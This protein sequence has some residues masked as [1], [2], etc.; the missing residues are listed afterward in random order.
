LRYGLREIRWALTGERNAK[1]AKATNSLEYE[2]FEFI[3]ERWEKAGRPETGVTIYRVEF[4]RR[5]DKSRRHIGR[6]LR[7]LEDPNDFGFIGRFTDFGERTR[8]VVLIPLTDLYLEH[9]GYVNSL[10]AEAA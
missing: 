7:K 2:V 8:F 3:R 10:V 5:F 9:E 1:D 6:L 4:E